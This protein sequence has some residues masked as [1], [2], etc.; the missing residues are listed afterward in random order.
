MWELLKLFI[1]AEVETF[2]NCIVNIY[3]TSTHSLVCRQYQQLHINPGHYPV[4][5]FN[6]TEYSVSSLLD[7][8][9][10]IILVIWS[11][12]TIVITKMCISLHLLC[13]AVH[14]H[15]AVVKLIK[16]HPSTQACIYS[17]DLVE[18]PEVG[19]YT[20]AAINPSIRLRSQNETKPTTL[21]RSLTNWQ[22]LRQSTHKLNKLYKTFCKQ[23]NVCTDFEDTFVNMYYS[24][25]IKH[26]I[27]K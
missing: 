12:Y 23:H 22:W 26:G 5:A 25:G 15:C 4:T 13:T 10:N 2:E 6:N 19:F 16:Y 21:Y 17:Q 11:F 7:T 14:L 1:G 8:C 24:P 18:P 20:P 9:S 27:K 3:L